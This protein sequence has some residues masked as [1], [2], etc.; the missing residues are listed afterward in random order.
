MSTYCRPSALLLLTVLLARSAP[1]LAT[2]WTKINQSPPGGLPS[3]V[4]LL[5]DG[6]ILVSG[7]E[8][9]STW[10]NWWAFTPDATGAYETSTT[11]MA[12]LAS[13]AYGRLFNPSFTLNTGQYM[14]CGG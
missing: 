14:I 5:T 6:R 13:S 4:T 12:P 8:S 9:S 11:T 3:N 10:N 2:P 7:A 1:S